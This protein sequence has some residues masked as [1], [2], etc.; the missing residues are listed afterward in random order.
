MRKRFSARQEQI[1]TMIVKGGSSEEIC[2]RLHITRNTLNMHRRRVLE[3]AGVRSIYH[4][5]GVA[6]V[7]GWVVMKP[8]RTPKS[9]TISYAGK[10]VACL[11]AQGK[12][13]AE[14][15]ELLGIPIRPVLDELYDKLETSDRMKL[16][17]RSFRAGLWKPTDFPPVWTLD[18]KA[19]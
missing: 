13:N 11:V 8:N 2:E 5:A 9:T 4:L 17:T 15:E 7:N 3:K 1:M 19:A 14:I 12:R 6:L 10:R 16:I 18:V